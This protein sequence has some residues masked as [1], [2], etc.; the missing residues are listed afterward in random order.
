MDSIYKINN[1]EIEIQ[2]VR[3]KKRSISVEINNK[4]QLI[5]RAPNTLTYKRIYEFLESKNEWIEKNVLL[6]RD[7]NKDVIDR[8]FLEGETFNYLDE[9]YKLFHSDKIGI[10]I[11]EKKFYV[12]KTSS[13]SDLIYLYKCLA[14]EYLISRCKYFSEFFKEDIKDIKIK[15]QKRRWGSCTYDNKINF[16]Y[17]IIMA[18]PEIIDYLVVHEM[19]HMPH[20][21][22]SKEFWD[23]VCSIL[24][25]AKELRQE[26]KSI[27]YRLDI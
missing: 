12:R 22:H 1:L 13:E 14:G 16:N 6:I 9:K 25:D 8:R 23:K 27:S 20:K 11:K 24:P 5:V 4:A 19:S 2:I 21:N 17:K 7:K 26:L 3:L 18:R 15:E 10:D